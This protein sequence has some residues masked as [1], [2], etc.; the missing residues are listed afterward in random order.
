[1]TRTML[2][3]WVEKHK[4]KP[5]D[6]RA[7]DE[8]LDEFKAEERERL[9]SIFN[10]YMPD[11][12]ITDATLGH[13]RYHIS[14]EHA[15]MGETF[16]LKA[17]GFEVYNTQLLNSLRTFIGQGLPMICWHLTE[18][19]NTI[20]T[21]NPATILDY[22]TV[23]VTEYENKTIKSFQDTFEIT[24]DFMV[25]SQQVNNTENQYHQLFDTVTKQLTFYTNVTAFIN[26]VNI[27]NLKIN[28]ERYGV[29]LKWTENNQTQQ[30]HIDTTVGYR[31]IENIQITSLFSLLTALETIYLMGVG[32]MKHIQATM[33]DK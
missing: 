2:N 24:M 18:L 22:L 8:L 27:T 16:T 30:V 4:S 1:M 29:D 19:T 11:V 13:D 6:L 32:T 26:A 23:M 25:N 5:V 33:N 10:D 3:S 7:L 31:P 28:I 9:T 12:K 17:N 20:K 21:T 15:G 14:Y